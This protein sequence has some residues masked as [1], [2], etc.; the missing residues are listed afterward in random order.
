MS[1]PKA[2][3]SLA[4]LVTVVAASGCINLDPETMAV[5]TP[6]IKEFISQHPNAEIKVTHFSANESENIIDEI[7]SDCGNEYIEPKDL[8]LSTAGTTDDGSYSGKKLKE[9]VNLFKRHYIQECL[10][11][12]DWSQTRTAKVLGIQ[13]TY[14]SRLIK[15]LKINKD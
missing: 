12:N 9:A 8:I 5:S 6:I 1:F 14:L 10:E 7:R 3:L 13:R 11:M 4:V 2:L 15:E